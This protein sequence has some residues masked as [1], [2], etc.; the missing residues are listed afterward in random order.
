MLTK[1]F[2]ENVGETIIV[3]YKTRR[4]QQQYERLH[5]FVNKYLG[6]LTNWIYGLFIGRPLET[7]ENR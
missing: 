4:K 7:A 1:C 6:Y 3:F 5:P 2:S